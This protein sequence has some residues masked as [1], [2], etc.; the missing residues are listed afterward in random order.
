M[1]KKAIFIFLMVGMGILAFNIWAKSRGSSEI[2][3]RDG[4]VS[5]GLGF[6]AK[7]FCSCL[8][9]SENSEESCRD[10]AALEQVSPRLTVDRIQKKTKSTLFYF[11]SREA[12]FLGPDQGCVL[13]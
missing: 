9:V 1:K 11:F 3:Y 7:A 13:L 2:E 10:Y 12:Q 5:L 6:T 8:F 4:V